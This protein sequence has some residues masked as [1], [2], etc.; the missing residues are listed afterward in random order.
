MP[1]QNRVTPTGEIEAAPARGLFMGNRGGR[2]HRDDKTLTTSRWKSKAWIICLLEFNGWHREVMGDSYT[3]LFF[4][5]EATALAA[6]HR[7]C[8]L[9]QRARAKAFAEALGGRL[10]A[11]QIDD[12]LHSQRRGA[13][14]SQRFGDLPPGAMIE[15]CGRAHLV[16]D[17]VLRPWAHGGYAPPVAC[18][19]PDV[20]VSCLTPEATLRALRNGYTPTLHPSAHAKEGNI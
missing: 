12:I 10:K 8:Y 6:G 5:D 16:T 7:P 13:P 3:E 18:P 14:A 20:Q 17:T 4:L 1:L 15:F 11:P 2:I 19:A 9:C